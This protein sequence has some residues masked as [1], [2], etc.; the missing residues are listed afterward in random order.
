MTKITQQKIKLDG[1]HGRELLKNYLT[2]HFSAELLDKFDALT[3]LYAQVNAVI[4]ISALRTADDIYVK[5]YLDSITAYEFFNGEC[6][7]VGCGGGFPCLP[8]SI[9]LPN[10]SFLGI[11]GV[12]K[13][14]TLINRCNEAL[15][16]TN[17]RSLHSRSEELARTGARFD[18]VCARAV[19][20]TDKVLSYC[21]PLAKSG[22]KIVL[23]KTKSDNPASDIAVKKSMCKFFLTKDYSLPGTDIN[24]RL[25]VY[26]KL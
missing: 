25:F 5:H 4:N 7:D 12:G 16:L 11:D 13:K 18:T 6:C 23:F 17:I 10:S 20:D 19:A 15:G 9:V 26:S 24:R 1:S 22:G 2:E 8:L 14:L 21:A 3:M